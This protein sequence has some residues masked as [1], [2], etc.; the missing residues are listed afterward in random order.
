MSRRL[1]IRRGPVSGPSLGNIHRSTLQSAIL[2]GVVAFM[3]VM[4]M[5][6]ALLPFRMMLGCV[7]LV[8]GYFATI[9]TLGFRCTPARKATRPAFLS[10]FGFCSHRHGDPRAPCRCCAR[11]DRACIACRGRETRTASFAPAKLRPP[12]RAELGGG[13]VRGPSR[14]LR[15]QRKRRGTRDPC[16]PPASRST[17]ASDAWKPFP[18]PTSSRSRSSPSIPRVTSGAGARAGSG[19]DRAYILKGK[20]AVKIKTADGDIF[21]GSNSPEELLALRRRMDTSHA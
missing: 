13:P 10:A 6:I 16:L 7:L 1:S 20:R 4:W 12:H 8:M 17:G 2:C 18:R 21:L 14:R 15:P 5:A 11:G 9:T 19:Q 3:I